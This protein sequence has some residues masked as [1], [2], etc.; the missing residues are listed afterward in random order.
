VQIFLRLTPKKDMEGGVSVPGHGLHCGPET[1]VTS[2]LRWL[3]FDLSGQEKHIS[4]SRG[5][6]NVV[7][8]KGFPK[9]V[10]SVGSRLHGFPCFPYSVISMAC[11]C[12][13][14]WVHKLHRLVQCVA[15]AM[16]NYRDRLSMSASAI[17]QSLRKPWRM[18]RQQSGV[19]SRLYVQTTF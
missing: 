7:I 19:D 4:S 12:P 2:P 11:F 3:W 10:G 16:N 15:P 17:M 13:A 6:G 18:N 9:S 14:T 8:P 5:S 1:S